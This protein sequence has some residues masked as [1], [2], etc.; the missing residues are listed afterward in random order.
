MAERG[1][2]REDLEDLRQLVTHKG[3]GSLLRGW[4][5]LFD[6]NG[7]LSVDYGTFIRIAGQ[8]HY[9]GNVEGIMAVQGDA[10]NFTLAELAPYEGD[11]MKRFMKWIK[12]E[13]GS[14]MELYAILDLTKKGKVSRESFIGGCLQ[15]GFEASQ[16][17]ME[18][19]FECCDPGD[20]GNVLKEEMVFLESDPGM[21][22]REALKQKGGFIRDW[23]Q[24]AAMEYINNARNVNSKGSDSSALP[25][26]HRLAPRPW[27]A[28]A[29]EN[30][31]LV[32][33]Q[34]RRDRDR[35]ARFRQKVA[36]HIFK[37]QLKASFG[38]QV[39]GIRRAVAGPDGCT[40]TLSDLRRYCRKVD[41]PVHI[42][43]LWDSLDLD[44][45]NRINLEEVCPQEGSAL[46]K[47]QVW[48]YERAGSVAGLWETEEAKLARAKRR[49]FGS[50]MADNKMKL[51]SFQEALEQIGWP[52]DSQ[53]RQTIF[54]A[55]DS[56]G[57][58]LITIEDLEWLDR[59]EA[60]E[61]LSAEPDEEAWHELK[62]LFIKAYKHPL[63]AWRVCLDRDNSNRLAWSEFQ[64]AC[65]KVRFPGNVGGAWLALDE[66]MS[67]YITMREYDLH[68]EELLTSFKEWAEVNFGSVKLCFKMLDAD[69]SGSV[70]YTELKR[71]CH[72]MQWPGDVRTLFDCIDID[73]NDKKGRDGSTGKRAISLDEIVFLDS[74][75]VE[76][77][78]EVARL[79]DLLAEA[80]A[81]KVLAASASPSQSLNMLRS[82]RPADQLISSPTSSPRSQDGS[83]PAPPASAPGG[84]RGLLQKQKT[85]SLVQDVDGFEDPTRMLK[86]KT[87]AKRG[88]LKR[89][90]SAPGLSDAVGL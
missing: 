39:R 21:R 32:V 41:M 70:T 60:P 59:W 34:R 38:N 80:E 67:G 25:P 22:Q 45:D 55:L 77:P 79:E 4:R 27:L 81:K 52:G 3:H 63:R 23:K 6:P 5:N 17:Q 11:L 85:T 90:S 65:K 51:K 42:K 56:L 7:E 44:M 76:P 30:I 24:K 61:Y 48:A 62:E 18:I 46:A 73:G 74:W 84:K 71:A 33:C 31:P 82:R 2:L 68:S 78:P 72:K 83:P 10:A 8:L 58:G 9:I 75:S 12:A 50:F 37:R 35:E 13:F 14:P 54:Q 36:R 69:R 19:I 20:I 89:A 66:D 86:K 16:D 88:L 40:T 15:R 1:N 47:F 29:F 64:E 49:G 57:C 53:E 43:D 87:N 28:N 26:K